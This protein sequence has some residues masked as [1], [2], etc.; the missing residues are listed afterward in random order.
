LN[1]ISKKLHELENNVVGD[2][3]KTK[4]VLYIEDA[5][6]REIHKRAGELLQRQQDT[7]KQFYNI[8]KENPKAE[9]N[10]HALDFTPDEKA[11]VDKSNIHGVD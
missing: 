9:V 5:T 3:P 2:A 11:I 10:I 6:E 1:P 7:A 4:T 8:L